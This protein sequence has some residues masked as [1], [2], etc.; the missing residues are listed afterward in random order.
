MP[1]DLQY[2]RA[3]I[4]LKVTDLSVT[5]SVPILKGVNIEIRNIKRPGMKQGQKVAL[6][7]PSGWGKTQLFKRLCG[8]KP[9]SSGTVLIGPE[10]LPVKS[11]MVGLVPQNYFLPPWRTVE[12][13]LLLAARMREPNHQKAIAKVLELLEQFGLLDKIH[14]YPQQLSGGQQQRISIIEQLLSSNHFVLMDEPF[15]GLDILAKRTV[16]SV[17]DSVSERDELNTIIFSTHD[18]QMAVAVADM[19]LILGHERD[20]HGKPIPGACIIK[21]ID[22]I[23]RNLCWHPDIEHIPEFAR[24]VAEIEAIF[25]TL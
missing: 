12:G 24:T 15:S 11:G 22:L 2:S 3:E 8:L 1:S 5:Y 4:L 20:A 10:Q 7:A 25:P 14:S 21:N 18:I 17:I 19:I 23:E 6:L 9:P 16:C 13:S